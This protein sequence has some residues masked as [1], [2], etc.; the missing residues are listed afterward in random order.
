MKTIRKVLKRVSNKRDKENTSAKPKLQKDNHLCDQT[1]S[2][3]LPS[4]S[5][6]VPNG[7]TQ[8]D[9]DSRGTYPSR[10]PVETQI[11]RQSGGDPVSEEYHTQSV[12]DFVVIGDPCHNLDNLITDHSDTQPQDSRSLSELKNAVA[13]FKAH[14]ELF[15][16]N[17]EGFVRIDDAIY[18]ALE[19][20]TKNQDMKCSAQIF[21]EEITT[22]LKIRERKKELSNATWTGKLGKFLMSL[23]PVAKLSLGLTSVVAEVSTHFSTFLI[24]GRKLFAAERCC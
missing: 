21:G 5:L 12:Q 1:S 16:K 9:S 18:P 24:K 19:K 23:Y 7:L 15:A 6:N 20:A 17:H 10:Y 13:D 14:Y 2:C 11:R 3:P 22:V 8:G 4:G